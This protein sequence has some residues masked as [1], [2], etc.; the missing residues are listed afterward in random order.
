MDII[1]L[2]IPKVTFTQVQAACPILK[3]VIISHNYSC[4]IY[5]CNIE[6]YKTFK[7]DANYLSDYFLVS[8]LNQYTDREL[9]LIDD[10]VNRWVKHIKEVNPIFL[11]ISLFSYESQKTA[12]IICEKLEDSGIKIILGGSGVGS[13]GR[14]GRSDYAE[15]LYNNN[16]IHAYVTGDG[17][18]AILQILQGKETKNT[19]S[20]QYSSIIDINKW[21]K[22]YPNYDDIELN[23][24]LGHVSIPITGSKGCVRQCGFC[25]EGR[26]AFGYRYRTGKS[27]AG[28]MIYLAN[29]YHINNFYFTDSL[30]NGSMKAYKEFIQV[31]L[32]E[33]A[34]RKK[35]ITWSGYFICRPK[36][37]MLVEDFTNSKL[38]GAN[39]FNIGIESGSEKVRTHMMK[40]FSNADMDYT[41]EQM[42]KQD[43]KLI[44]LLI[45]GYP[46]ET[47]EDFKETLELFRR[48]KKYSDS[49]IIYE[50]NVGSTC[51]VFPDRPVYVDPN[52]LY[53]DK[54][55]SKNPMG[56][57]NTLN[58]ELD[59]FE[60]KRRYDEAVTLLTELNY[61]FRGVTE[62]PED[63]S[64]VMGKYAEYV[65]PY[66]QEVLRTNQG[67]LREL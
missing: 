11:G 26:N 64:K 25:T 21:A 42:S 6:F 8:C 54:F 58:P 13:A 31:M 22:F 18:E 7:E 5:D 16:L 4:K 48:W 52:I 43:I 34:K 45:I 3:G 49:G 63:W 12:T 62:K 28:E 47:R 19:N 33:N 27:I 29:K 2:T 10:E 67:F 57:I 17:E 59:M 32:E 14:I 55:N 35:K 23:E 66:E 30:I 38:A 40:K 37:G 65:Q 50:L 20:I 39:M 15:S 51:Q 41:L 36:R 60:R 61:N 46:Y 53:T 1:L 56:W 24:Y 44:M 9:K